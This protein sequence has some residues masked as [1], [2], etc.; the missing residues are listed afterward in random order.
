MADHN[1]PALSDTYANFLAYLSDRIKDVLLGGDPASTTVTNPPTNAIRWELTTN[2]RL[3][4]YNGSAWVSAEPSGGYNQNIS[5]NAATA[6]K[7]ATGRTITTTGDATG[8]SGA[9]DG[10]A[11]LSFALTLANSGASAGT[12]G[13]A[14]QAPVVTVDAKGRITSVSNITVTPAWGSITGKPT[15]LGGYGIT[16]A[17]PLASPTFTGTVTLPAGST[18]VAP[19][20]W[21]AGSILTTPA[22]H[23]HE[24]DGTNLWQ[25]TSG[26]V[27]RQIQYAGGKRVTAIASATSMTPNM[28]TTDVASMVNT[29]AAGTFTINNPSGTP[30]DGQALVIRLRATNAQTF[31]WGTKYRGS[32]DLSLPSVSP[33]GDK[34]IYLGFLYNSTDDKIDIVSSIGGF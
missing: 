32:T 12:Y 24:W 19:L 14:T 28:D 3:E 21:K 34:W 1:K 18:T 7:W 16:D 9:F 20:K 6:T 33:S 23:A 27:R 17:A 29:Q 8:T 4:K 30:V 31:S 5:G 11:N 22:A 25:T 2:K 10:S 15:T 26:A 13:S